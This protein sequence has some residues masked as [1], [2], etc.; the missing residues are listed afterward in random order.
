MLLI[1]IRLP[2][3][4]VLILVRAFGRSIL[5]PWV[6]TPRRSVRHT[7]L[8][9]WVKPI[10]GEEVWIERWEGLLWEEAARPPASPSSTP[11]TT[12][13]SPPFGH[14]SLRLQYEYRR[15]MTSPTLTLEINHY[16]LIYRVPITKQEAA[17]FEKASLI[18]QLFLHP[19]QDRVC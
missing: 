15:F 3:M 17:F 7:L 19:D 4:M 2:S 6:R 14:K 1:L 11:A 12:T 9:V 13:T 8:H 5:T 16:K 10:F 18:Y